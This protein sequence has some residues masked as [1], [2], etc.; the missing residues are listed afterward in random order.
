MKHRS[1]NNCIFTHIHPVH[2]Y[3]QV[4]RNVCAMNTPAHVHVNTLRVKDS[5]HNMFFSN[6]WYHVTMLYIT[7]NCFSYCVRV[8]QPS[9]VLHVLWS[10]WVCVY[11]C[12]HVLFIY[13][14]MIV[15][16][17]LCIRCMCMCYQEPMTLYGLRQADSSGLAP[18][19]EN[20]L[21]CTRCILTIEHTGI[22][23]VWYMYYCFCT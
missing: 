21:D 1:P 16:M 3:L 20:I 18:D 15:D 2:A 4:M 11:T 12:V 8:S 13:T 17:F 5:E 6:L 14:I 10:A 19:M 23:L 7:D 22:I 9:S